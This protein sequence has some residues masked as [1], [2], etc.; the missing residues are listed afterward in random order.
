MKKLVLLFICIAVLITEALPVRA[1]EKIRITNGEW[2][3]YLSESLKYYGIA[4][5]IITEA[6]ALEG[7]T[8]EYGFFP[9][10]RSL[11]M[12]EIGE[13]DGSAVWLRSPEREAAFF[14]SDPVID[15]CYVFFHL[16]SFAFD[17]E[18]VE[19]LKKIKIGGTLGYNYGEAFEKAEKE[20]EIMVERV[21]RDEQ[22]LMKLLRQRI[23]L[24]PLD[25]YVGYAMLRKN[26]Q[27][28]EIKLFTNHDKPLRSD[29]LHLLLTKKNPRNE[30]MIQ[31][32]NKGLRKLRES[33]KIIQYLQELKDGR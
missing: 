3:P 32:F 15:S 30:E 28:D 33:G 7:I 6:F 1:A 20:G 25:V 18:T 5:R 23:Q 21:P 24:F 31:K 8:V 4:S 26:F 16:K 29:P 11:I 9:W 13:W 27:P 12:A 22:N 2:P 14:L 17:W 19:D 10:K